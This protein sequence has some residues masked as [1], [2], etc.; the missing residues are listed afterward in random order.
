[1]AG[2]I[3]RRPAVPPPIRIRRSVLSLPPDD[4]ILTF[5]GKAMAA[6]MPKPLKE[7]TSWRYQAAIHDYIRDDDPKAIPNEELAPDANRFW[8]ACEHQAW[9]FLP[10]HRMYLFHFEQM[11]LAEV[12]K[13]GGPTDWALPY[14][15]YSANDS[16]RIL[17]KAFQKGS[18]TGLFIENRDPNAND[19]KPFLAGA[20]R[21]PTDIRCLLEPQ[22]EGDL[23]TSVGF[24]GLQPRDPRNPTTR[25]N[26]KNHGGGR[27]PTSGRCELSPHNGIHGALNG[28]VGDNAPVPA[29]KKGFMGNFT[30]APLDPIF[31]VHHCNIDRLWEVWVHTAGHANPTTNDWLNA[32]SWD[33]HTAD[34]RI[35]T[36]KSEDVLD[37]RKQL[38]YEYDDISNPLGP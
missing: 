9:F 15:H 16:A 25:Q 36:M 28:P 32:V 26:R 33:F 29:N 12:I 4:P 24:G 11:V 37:T 19:G 6:M 21:D 22:F 18:T 23:G 31:W 3:V 1:M 27:L 13:Q 38:S 17:P 35:A 5:Y 14:W 7:P 34:G 30:R 2:E 10:W 20:P 8:G